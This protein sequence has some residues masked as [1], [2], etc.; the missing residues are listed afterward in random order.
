MSATILAPDE[1]SFRGEVKPYYNGESK[2]SGGGEQVQ[3]TLSRNLVVKGKVELDL[4][5][6]WGF[7]RAFAVR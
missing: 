4:G 7:S 5:L 1:S 3:A 6:T 2:K